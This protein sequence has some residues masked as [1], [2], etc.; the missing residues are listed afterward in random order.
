[1]AMASLRFILLSGLKGLEDDFPIFFI[2]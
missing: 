1:M 2:N